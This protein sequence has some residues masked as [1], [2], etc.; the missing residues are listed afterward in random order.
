MSEFNAVCGLSC[1]DTY[2]TVLAFLKLLD[3]SSKDKTYNARSQVIVTASTAGF[4]RNPR[5]GY[6]YLSSKAA[7]IS[8]IKKFSTFCVEESDLLPCSRV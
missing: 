4:L 8:L 3:G 5:T 2:Y 6:E 1:T 7:V